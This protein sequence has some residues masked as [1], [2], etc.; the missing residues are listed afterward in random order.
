MAKPLS[1]TVVV[2][3]GRSA[4]AKSGKKGALRQLHPIDMGGLVLKGV[5]EKT[6]QLD[7]ALAEDVI[8]GRA[9]VEDCIFKVRERMRSMAGKDEAD[10]YLPPPFRRCQ[11][12]PSNK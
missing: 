6:P 8:L 11:P 3:Y 9:T 4:V 10:D 2:A 12:E 1:K 7:A 5:M